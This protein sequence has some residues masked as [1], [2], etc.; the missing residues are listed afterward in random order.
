[1]TK[2]NQKLFYIYQSMDNKTGIPSCIR[3]KRVPSSLGKIFK[4][5]GTNQKLFYIYQKMDNRT[6]F[7]LYIKTKKCSIA[8]E[9]YI[10]WSKIVKHNFVSIKTRTMKLVFY[11]VLK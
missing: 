4:I 5:N 3:T 9:K 10:G 8:L 6:G 1:M 2:T 11:Y 7:S